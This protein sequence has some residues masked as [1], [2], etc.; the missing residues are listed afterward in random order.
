MNIKHALLFAAGL[1]LASAAQ[2]N[3]IEDFESGSL[4]AYANSASGTLSAASAHDGT[5]GLGTSNGG[6]LYR[7]DALVSEGDTLSVW[8]MFGGLSGR[9]YFGFGTTAGGTQ[10]FV[11]APNTGDIRFQNNPGFNFDELDT[12]AQTFAADHWYRAEVLW[13]AGGAVTGNLYDSDGTTLLNS[14]SSTV[15]FSSAGGIAFR[16]FGGTVSFDTVE[17]TNVPEP[18]TLALLGLGFVGLAFSKRRTRS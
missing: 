14:V 10:S 9:A 15:S 16:G 12:S 17:V 8:V 5:L 18:A 1:A 3:V 2:A 4:A 11:L 7:T 13:G 6:W